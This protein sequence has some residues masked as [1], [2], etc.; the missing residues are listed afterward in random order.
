M[1]FQWRGFLM[2]CLFVATN[3]VYLNLL[4]L[5]F[6]LLGLGIFGIAPATIAVMKSLEDFRFDGDYIPVRQFFSHYKEA[7][8]KSNLIQIV[9]TIA[10][11]AFY[12]SARIL[13]V[14]MNVTGFIPVLYFTVIVVLLFMNTLSL[15]SI[16]DYPDM[17]G[18]ERIK[19]GL[20][21]F[22][23]YPLSYVPI[24]FTIMGCYLIISMKSAFLLF[25]G[26]S[27]PIIVIHY[28]QK[29]MIEKFK[30]DFPDFG[31]VQ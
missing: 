12:M 8:K 2:K 30:S 24:I 27:L 13:I 5:L 19:L 11:F 16:L 1:K 23:R 3:V 18:L 25:F 26:A 22:M 7:F 10:V 14:L 15:Q 17:K 9:Y 20:F 6:S 31:V 29:Q 28:L 21:L 4:W